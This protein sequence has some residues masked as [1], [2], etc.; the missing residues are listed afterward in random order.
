MGNNKKPTTYIPTYPRWKSHDLS[1]TKIYRVWRTMLDRCNL[2]T[3]KSFP[4]YGGRGIKV[5]ERWNN[6]RTFVADMGIPAP[7]MTID[8]I[9]N[10]GPYS[11]QNC[12]WVN[13]LIQARNKRN[14]IRLTFNKETLSLAEWSIRIGRPRSCLY[15]RWQKGMPIEKI[16]DPKRNK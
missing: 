13:R 11:P 3:N 4:N 2:P 9:N 14:N 7:G 15:Y 12:R 6:V 10:D 16:L 8:R 1:Y 5:C